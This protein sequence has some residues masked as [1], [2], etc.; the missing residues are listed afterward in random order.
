MSADLFTNLYNFSN[1]KMNKS[2]ETIHKFP[3]PKYMD[4]YPWEGKTYNYSGWHSWMQNNWTV[5]FWFC[6]V[7]FLVIFGGKRWMRNRQPFKLK[8]P[9]FL[10][11]SGLAVYSAFTFWRTFPELLYLIG[12]EN[13]LHESVCTRD[14]MSIS[15]VF[16][17][18][19]FTWSKVAEL[20]DTVFIVLR[21]SPLI[22]LHW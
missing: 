2:V 3:Y 18:M 22:I 11:N 16:W 5:S 20:F 10:W 14:T 13:G 7:Y 4:L 6:A 21:K 8:G 15:V 12:K 17:S 1:T 9:L 19:L